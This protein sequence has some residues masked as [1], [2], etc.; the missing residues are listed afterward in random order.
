MAEIDDNE[1]AILKRAHGLLDS[2]YND[3]KHGMSFKKMMKEKLPDARIPELDIVENVTKPYD[4]KISALEAENKKFREDMEA[5]QKKQADREEEQQVRL[6]LDDVQKKY[7]LTDDGMSKVVERMKEKNNPDA[8]AAA[9][10][11]LRQQPTPKPATPAAYLPSELNLYGS[12]TADEQYA[13]LNKDPVKWFDRQCAEI[14][15]GDG[16]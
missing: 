2:L 4:E 3:P 16:E 9:A 7:K 14:L 1:L 8:E 5:W 6:T 11:I 12:S 13:D 10:F 15:N